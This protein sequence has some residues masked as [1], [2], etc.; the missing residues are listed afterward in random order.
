MGCAWKSNREWRE[1]EG[2]KMTSGSLTT[3]A[4]GPDFC[5]NTAQWI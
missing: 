5:S 3:R 4:I 2:F 1:R